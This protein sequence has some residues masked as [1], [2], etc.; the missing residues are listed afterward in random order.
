MSS[1]KI[2]AFLSF[3]FISGSVACIRHFSSL[4][5]KACS[6]FPSEEST[7]GEYEIVNR[8][9]NMRLSTK[10]NIMPPARI[11]KKYFNSRSICLNNS[12]SKIKLSVNENYFSIHTLPL[13]MSSTTA[14]SNRVEVSPKLEV[15]PSATFL[16]ILRIIF[17]LLVF[18]KP[19]T[20]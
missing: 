14:G 5:R 18:G 2:K 19:F 20:I 10:K 9:G 17:P 6:T 16:K 11:H 4:E 3:P 15:S 13:T 7:C 1:L 12:L 8:S